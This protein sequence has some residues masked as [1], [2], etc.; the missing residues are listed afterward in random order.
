[1]GWQSMVK[2]NGQAAVV[3]GRVQ[4]VLA[5]NLSGDLILSAALQPESSVADLEQL[6][7]TSLSKTWTGA[8]FFLGN[9]QVSLQSSLQNY[10]SLVVKEGWIQRSNNGVDATTMDLVI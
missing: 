8:T 10:D 7:I 1:M 6:L 3:R 9:D 4:N 2:E 5:G